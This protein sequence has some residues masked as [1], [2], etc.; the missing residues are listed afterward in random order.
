[1]SR[2]NEIGRHKTNITHVGLDTLVTYHSTP[3]VTFDEERVVLN[4]GGWFTNTT[5]LRMNQTANQYNLGF[6]VYQHKFDWYVSLPNGE[7]REFT[8]NTIEF[9]R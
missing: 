6:G 7:T 9:S 1:M 4:T 3:V 8:S 2:Y 5:K